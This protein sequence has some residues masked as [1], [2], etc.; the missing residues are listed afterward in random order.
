VSAPV[1]PVPG[2]AAAVVPD[3]DDAGVVVGPAGAPLTVPDPEQA[4]AG[5]SHELGSS[6]PIADP[7]CEAPDAMAAH[8]HG[9]WDWNMARIWAQHSAGGVE[10]LPMKKPRHGDR[11]ACAGGHAAGR[12]GTAGAVVAA[13]CCG[14]GSGS[15]GGC[16]CAVVVEAAHIRPVT[17]RARHA[18]VAGG[19]L[20]CRR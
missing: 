2:A 3:P 11:L 7:S 8:R 9:A 20:R 17:A 4:L 19:K 18:M 16:G 5:R 1:G 14:S 15:G 10:E 13:G 6:W 12:L